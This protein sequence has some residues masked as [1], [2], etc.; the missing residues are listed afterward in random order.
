MMSFRGVFFLPERCDPPA[1]PGGENGGLRTSPMLGPT[2]W[3][4]SWAAEGEAQGSV[5]SWPEQAKLYQ[6]ERLAKNKVL[7]QLF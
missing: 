2:F 4:V 3:K 5:D 6:R 1:S 7:A